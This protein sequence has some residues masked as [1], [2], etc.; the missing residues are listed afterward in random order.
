M[1][2]DAVS[3]IMDDHR[4]M[5]SLFAQVQSG[6]GDRTALVEEIAARLT[7][8]A[9][10]EEQKVYPALSKAKPSESD[11]VEHGY[12]EH[13][14]AEELLQK[15]I[16][17]L[18]SPQFEQMFTEFV[19]AVTHHVE[20]EE[21]E[22]L[23]A[24]RDAVDTATLEQLGTAFTEV[25]LRELREA[26]FDDTGSAYAAAYE[27]GRSDLADATRDELYEMAKEADIPG[28]STMKKDELA[29]A[30]REQD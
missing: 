18:D 22:I 7:A 11:E 20:E 28:R 30:L 4:M 6:K 16:R 5:E 17:N 29:D 10:A 13:D 1:A 26:G 24:L 27:K 19:D 2:S 14:E 9:N 3:L 23:P 21:S 15:A 25:R 8:H 12:H